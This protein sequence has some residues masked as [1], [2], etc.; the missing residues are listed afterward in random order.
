MSYERLALGVGATL[1]GLNV[2]KPA[3]IRGES[4]VEHK[5]T[6]VAASGSQVYAFDIYAEVGEVEVI[7]TYIK[8]LDTGATTSVVCLSGKAKPEAQDL[9]AS[10]GIDILGPKEVEDF[11]SKRVSQMANPP[12]GSAEQKS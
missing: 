12:R 9:S 7:R 6:F 8:K 11:F 1:A 2:V 3:V 5:F 4:G 10:Y